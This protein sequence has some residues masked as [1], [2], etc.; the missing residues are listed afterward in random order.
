MKIIIVGG[1]I[2]GLTTYLHLRKHLPEPS[3]HSITIL[4]SHKSLRPSQPSLKP[5]SLDALSASTAIVGGG[6]GIAPNGMR[7]LR[8]LDP[9]LHARVVAQGFRAENFV[10]KAAKGWMLGVQ[11]TCDRREGGEEV[12]VASSRH[13]L[14]E[15]TKDYV[16]ET[17]GKEV[18]RY[19]K[20]VKLERIDGEMARVRYVNDNGVEGVETADLVIGA[21]G[22][23]SV[24]RK[25]LFG[26]D[27]RYTP[28]YT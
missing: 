7:A 25:T 24:V 26:E 5:V 4:E 11:S 6:L 21:D 10:F 22:V 16:D 18:V 12:C 17:Y 20:V 2:A 8:D 9:V 1:G 23:K 19:A 15:T 27:E 3:S 28:T 14:W 13:G